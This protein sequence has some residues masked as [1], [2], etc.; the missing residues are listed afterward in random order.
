MPALRHRARYTRGEYWDEGVRMM[1]Y[2]SD[3]LDQLPDGAT[4]LRPNRAV[5][6]RGVKVALQAIWRCL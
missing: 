3:Y 2:W 4:I 1:Q 6:D 5:D